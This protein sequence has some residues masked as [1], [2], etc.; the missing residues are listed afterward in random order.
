[1]KRG[2]FY[3][4][5][6][7]LWTKFKCVLGDISLTANLFM[8]YCCSFYGCQLWDLSSTWFDVIHVAW[9]KAG[10]RIFQLPHNAHSFLLPYVVNGIPIRDQLLKRCVTFYDARKKTIIQ[11]LVSKTNVTFENTPMGTNMKYI[12]MHSKTKV[13]AGSEEDGRGQL[14]YCITDIE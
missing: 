10:R 2:H 1:M 9:N 7:K 11:L 4:L 5:A 3:G 13:K 8:S 6:N 14:L 12:A